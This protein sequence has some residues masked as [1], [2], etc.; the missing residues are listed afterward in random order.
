MEEDQ[1]QSSDSQKDAQPKKISNEI[2]NASHQKDTKIP[3]TDE[4]GRKFH[5]PMHSLC[6]HRAFCG[7]EAEEVESERQ[8]PKKLIQVSNI[9]VMQI[10]SIMI[11]EGGSSGALAMAVE[12]KCGVWRNSTY[13]ITVSRRLQRFFGRWECKTSEAAKVIES[14]R[15]RSKELNCD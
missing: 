14:L 3:K 8:S 5:R 6:R 12:M 2:L 7:L 4:A 11:G 15:E 10:L 9:K 13:S 1:S